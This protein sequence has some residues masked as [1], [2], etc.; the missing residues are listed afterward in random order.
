VNVGRVFNALCIVAWF[1]NIGLNI[2]G[3][4]SNNFDL[5]LLSLGNMLL[6]SFVLIREPKSK[7]E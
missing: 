2:F 1:V 6:L 5:Q 7:A 3:H 4:I